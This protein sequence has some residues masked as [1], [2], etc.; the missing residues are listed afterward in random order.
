MRSLWF[1]WVMLASNVVWADMPA[2][3]GPGNRDCADCPEMV[4]VPAGKF[5]MGSPDHEEG[6]GTDEGPL[7]MVTFVEPF[8]IGRYEVTFDEWD[9]CVAAMGDG[10]LCPTH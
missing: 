2:F 5:Q 1:G 6:R 9:A 3:V 4:V 7:H 10:R 8:A